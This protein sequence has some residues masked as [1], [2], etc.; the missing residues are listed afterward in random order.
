MIGRQIFLGGAAII[1]SSTVSA[2]GALVMDADGEELAIK[3]FPQTTSPITDVDLSVNV[4]GDPTGINLR[5]RVESDNAD[6][7]SGTILG[8]TNNAISASFNHA[9]DGFT[10]LKALGESTGNLTV[11]VPVWLILYRFDGAS[12]SGTNYFTFQGAN[13]TVAINFE[14]IRNR[15]YTA[16]SWTGTTA[17]LQRCGYVVKHLD[18]TY[19]G[20]P[21]ISS[22]GSP[23]A[24]TDIHSN[25]RHGIRL[26]SGSQIKLIGFLWYPT[27]TGSPNALVAAV[28]EGS[29]LKHS[30]TILAANI[31]TTV[32]M[33]VW[34]SSPVLLAA[35]TNL[36]IVLGQEAD[37]GGGVLGTDGGDDSN[38]YDSR[39]VAVSSTYR[40]AALPADVAFVYGTGD[41]PTAYTVSNTDIPYIIPIISDPATDLDQAA[42]GGGF[43]ILG[44]SVVR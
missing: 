16:G 19:D 35:D 40:S 32:W 12:L 28:F 5:I 7:P 11:N 24:A 29:A 8:A 41:D 42:A 36:Y 17:V 33:P 43:P 10:G 39:V 21:Q 20:V 6:A 25:Y 9:A 27:K 26:K 31:I 15:V 23:S 4:V 18:D 30:N 2:T 38:D 37:A 1:G 14:A 44:G 3:Y 34:F 13:T 22:L